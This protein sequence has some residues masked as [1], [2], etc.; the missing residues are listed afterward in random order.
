MG[1]GLPR[2]I[3][4]EKDASYYVDTLIKGISCV[5][6][7]TEKGPVGTP[8]LIS[9]AMQFERV[10]GHD[11]KTSDFPLL[12]KR[13]LAYGAVLWVSRVAHY[14][15][16]TDV[17]T[18]TARGASV[19][20]K[21]RAETPVATLKVT[22]SSPGTWGNGLKVRIS[23]SSMDSGALF[24]VEIVEGDDVVETLPDLSMDDDSDS[25]VEKQ[26]SAYIVLTDLAS[27]SGAKID[28]P[29][30]GTFPLTGGNDGLTGICDADYIGSATNG[31]G[32]HAFDDITD[33]VQLA[34][35]G[36]S[37]PAVISAG[38]GYCENRGDLLFVTETPFDLAAQEAVDF[39]LGKGTYSHAPFV[40][41]YGAMYWP[42]LKIYDVAQQKERLVS[43]VGDVLGVM[44][45]NDWT[46]NE[47]YVPAGMRRGRILNALGVDVN[48]G[49]RGR[50]GE[51]NY[52][53]ENQVDPIC[54]FDDTGPVV[55]GAQTLQR[56]ASLLREVNVRRM[57]IV[58]KKTLAAYARAFIHQPND[59]RTWREFYRG[60]EPKFR[61]W[62]AERW[63][64]DYRIF[65]DQDANSLEEA[66][67]N[68]PESVQ[69]GEFKCLTFIKP[70]VGIKWVLLDAV[71]TRLD[72][73]FSESL[74]DV[75]GITA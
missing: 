33:A 40:S 14:S 6:G 19:E 54:V 12:A 24:T 27:T 60:L 31:T 58:V 62:K 43:P 48:V 47:S 22:A 15:D 2:V 52:L 10:F 55:W 13:A 3:V 21:D 45:V 16:I 65:C 61:E 9:S 17:A 66:K 26:K 35:P 37:S 56:Q 59:P 64:Y 74:T 7:I 68:I 44:S 57:L 25:Y 32:L 39:R 5:S 70:V 29:A 41:N 34:V 11:L 51:G 67:L 49:G 73:N 53:C 69:R 28:R 75:L 8:Q 38:L 20:L 72:A 4:S 46:E 23:D 18:L 71:I 50:L 1:F 36:V 63:F 30:L 42:K